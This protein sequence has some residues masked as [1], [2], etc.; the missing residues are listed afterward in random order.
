MS[1]EV[2]L[3]YEADSIIHRLDP[4][5]KLLWFLLALAASIATQYDGSVGVF[6]F[7][8][9]IVGIALAK[10]SIKRLILIIAYSIVFFI[11]TILVWAS[12]YQNVGRQVF[13]ISFANLH[14]TDVGLLVGTGKFF[15]I[16]NPITAIL[17]FFSTVKPYDLVQTFDRLKLPYKAGFIFFLSLRLL[18]ITFREL[19]EI[20]DVQKSRGIEVDSPN[21]VKRIANT[22]PIFVPLI[23]RIMSVTWEMAITL[24]VRGFGAG[25]RS[26]VKPLKWARRDTIA[27]AVLTTF[28][29]FIIIIT[30]RG[31]S[32][33]AFIEGVRGYGG[34]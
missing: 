4:R 34:Y 27:L 2:G 19:R 30:L 22:I 11:V 21:P 18:P 12:F 3:Y 6:V 26:Y 23:I 33:Y 7:I 15:L 14:V 1:S 20:M 9:L 5:V 25:K 8:S 31:F 29:L 17:L 13:Y 32:T 10:L 28:Y 16:V 24:M